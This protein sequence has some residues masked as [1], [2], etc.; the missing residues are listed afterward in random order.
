MRGMI[1]TSKTLCDLS[2]IYFI[3]FDLES[4]QEYLIKVTQS[5]HFKIR[6]NL[7]NTRVEQQE[8]RSC[9][10]KKLWANFTLSQALVLIL[11]NYVSLHRT[12]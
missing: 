5:F 4:V 2:F 12:T 7:G 11:N 10:K 1:P 3:F 9:G 6:V 8:A